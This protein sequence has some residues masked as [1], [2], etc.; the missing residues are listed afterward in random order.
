MASK[1]ANKLERVRRL[2]RDIGIP[3]DTVDKLALSIPRAATLIDLDTRT[4]KQALDA[5]GV[6]II[7]ICN[8]DRIDVVDFVEFL[9][10]HRVGRRNQREKKTRW[11]LLSTEQKNALRHAGQPSRKRRRD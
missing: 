2:A 8:L 3:L 6:Q 7:R 9:E 4:L 1:A 10:R 5:D 11:D